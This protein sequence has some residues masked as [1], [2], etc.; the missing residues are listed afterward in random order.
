MINYFFFHISVY[1]LRLHCSPIITSC[2]SSNSPRRR[3]PVVGS[4]TYLQ[5]H[6]QNIASYRPLSDLEFQPGRATITTTTLQQNHTHKG[7][8]LSTNTPTIYP[9]H[10]H[11]QKKNERERTR[12]QCLQRDGVCMSH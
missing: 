6:S 2:S 8:N 3:L 11:T 1:T 4:T 9:S 10:F 7:K 5:P 12:Q